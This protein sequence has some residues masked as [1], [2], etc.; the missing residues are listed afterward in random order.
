MVLLE[1]L[2]EANPDNAK[3]DDWT[4]AVAALKTATPEPEPEAE[5]KPIE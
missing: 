5:Q 1:R 3:L 4:V 2:R